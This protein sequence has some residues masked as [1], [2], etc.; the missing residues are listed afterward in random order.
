M[1]PSFILVLG[2]VAA[3]YD[4]RALRPLGRG[5]ADMEERHRL[6][7]IALKFYRTGFALYLGSLAGQW[8][9]SWLGRP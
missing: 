1:I 7:V 8:I 5:A 2:C 6:R 4:A 9:V 3:F